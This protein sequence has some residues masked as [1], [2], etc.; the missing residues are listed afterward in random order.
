[1]E[2]CVMR[3]SLAT[4]ECTLCLSQGNPGGV[5]FSRKQVWLL[6]HEAFLSVGQTWKTHISIHLKVDREVFPSKPGRHFKKTSSKESTREAE[7][8]WCTV[9]VF[10]IKQ[11]FV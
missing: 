10:E 6:I 11:S 3:R 1:M 7:S 5:D 2:S 8:T 4:F 9:F